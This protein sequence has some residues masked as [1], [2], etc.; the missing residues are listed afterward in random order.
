MERIA[1]RGLGASVATL[2]CVCALFAGTFLA[3]VALGPA[4][5]RLVLQT[6]ARR[7]EDV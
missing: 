7:R 2:V 4:R 3:Y 1:V 5:R 6:F